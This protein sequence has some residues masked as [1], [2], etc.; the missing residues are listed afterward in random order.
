M[1]E[2]KIEVAVAA[3]LKARIDKGDNSLQ[4]RQQFEAAC[5]RARKLQVKAEMLVAL[6]DNTEAP[7]VVLD[8][9]EDA[10]FLARTPRGKQ[11]YLAAIESVKRSKY[12]RITSPL[13]GNNG[14]NYT[15]K[16]FGPVV[17]DV[18]QDVIE[19][20][21]ED[22]EDPFHSKDLPVTVRSPSPA[23]VG[24]G[25]PQQAAI[26][27]WESPLK[28]AQRRPFE[29]HIAIRTSNSFENLPV[30]TRYV[31]TMAE[32]IE[33][34]LSES[35]LIQKI[36]TA[37][38]ETSKAR[39]VPA[40]PKE[41]PNK[42]A[43]AQSNSF[44]GVTS[45]PPAK[46]T[47]GVS[48]PVG[49]R[50]I[51]TQAECDL[52]YKGIDPSK[53]RL[54]EVYLTGIKRTKKSLLRMA[55]RVDGIETNHIVDIGFVGK[56]ITCFLVPVEFVATFIGSLTKT[57]KFTILESFDP[58]DITFMKDLP[59]YVGK[60]DGELLIIARKLAIERL[61]RH[62]ERLQ[63]SRVGT[64]KY[65]ALKLKKLEQEDERVEQGTNRPRGILISDFVVQSP[66]NTIP[67]T[68]VE[69]RSTELIQNET[70]PASFAYLLTDEER[71]EEM[72]DASS[73]Q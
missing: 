48:K 2:A 25:T 50:K 18:N 12:V 33:R 10:A 43:A 67:G 72:E 55:L 51:M 5:A 53:K 11:V 45:I 30:D 14:H 68:P 8:E 54:H 62:M 34:R 4:T 42:Q 52:V 73:M 63:E 60:T 38:E 23:V 59:Q 40:R 49:V 19:V 58:L 3:E 6:S 20:E 22:N 21:S 39:S 32:A 7:E 29:P 47:E 17:G 26:L 71:V 69:G 37:I 65:Y 46:G 57:K 24:S 64:R 61:R 28:P 13:R 35:P 66:Q 70:T 36:L 9:P 15:E 44:A 1:R 56:S 31:E 16:L 27:Q 41:H